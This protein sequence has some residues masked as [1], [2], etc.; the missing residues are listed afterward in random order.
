MS[1]TNLSTITTPATDVTTTGPSMAD[2]VG[3]APVASDKATA[4]DEKADLKAKTAVRTTFA[5][6]VAVTDVEAWLAAN[7]NGSARDIRIAGR[8]RDALRRKL[9]EK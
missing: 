6:A 8:A 1:N 3:I 5:V 2:S 7:P 4:N 9:G